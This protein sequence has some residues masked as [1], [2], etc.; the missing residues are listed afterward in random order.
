MA[1]PLIGF[2][3]G[4]PG[5]FTVN[6]AGQSGTSLAIKGGTPRYAFKEGQPFSM[7]VN[8]QSYFD[9]IAAPTIAD[10]SGNATITL[11]QMLRVSPTNGA[12]LNF[13]KPIFEGFVMG[14]ALSWEL[15][16][17]RHVGLSFDIAEA[18]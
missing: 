14:D 1:Y 15:S 7:I 11:T 2:N 8:G 4:S 13:A 18:R 3:P 16:L 6:G 10:A 5:A 9:F 12:A 17:E